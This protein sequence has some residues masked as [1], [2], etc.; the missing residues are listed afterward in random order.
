MNPFRTYKCLLG[1]LVALLLFDPGVMGVNPE[2]KDRSSIMLG[3]ARVHPN[4][5]F[6]RLINPNKANMDRILR[7]QGFSL[8]KQ[9]R[10]VEGLLLVDV[11]GAGQAMPP[12]DKAVFLNKRM[13]ELRLSG[14]F[15]YVEPNYYKEFYLEPNDSAYT[16]GDLW[17][18]WNIGQM[19][20]KDDGDIDAR[21]AWDLTTG[22]KEI[23]VSVIDSGVR[24]THQDLAAQMWINEDE[25]PGNGVDDDNDGYVDNINGIDA[26][27]GDGD[28]EDDISAI[29]VQIH[30]AYFKDQR[31]PCERLALVGGGEVGDDDAGIHIAD[32]LDAELIEKAR[33]RLGDHRYH[34]IVGQ[35]FAGIDIGDAN[36]KLGSEIE[37]VIRKF[38]GK[39]CHAL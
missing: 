36:G 10:L 29:F 18:L 2:R 25:I 39:A 23:I 27:W 24:V 26:Y 33:A 13:K 32:F 31:I 38:Q 14:L 34:R 30:H 12:R 8:I 6:A 1:L 17:G 15:S 5:V 3:E 16:D 19:N 9:Y 20:G 37:L 4:L 28:P 35:V 7:G 22:N 11:N 21:E